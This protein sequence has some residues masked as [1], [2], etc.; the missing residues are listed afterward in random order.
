MFHGLGYHR[1]ECQ[2]KNHVDCVDGELWTCTRCGLVTCPEDGCADA[3]PDLCD[4]CWVEVTREEQE[5]A[6]A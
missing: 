4:N 2:S 5:H 3:Y 1:D 6:E